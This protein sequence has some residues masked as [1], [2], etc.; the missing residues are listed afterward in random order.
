MVEKVVKA[1]IAQRTAWAWALIVGFFLVLVG[2]A[3]VVPIL[4]G[5]LLAV[6]AS[7]WH[8]RSAQ[9]VEAPVYKEFKARR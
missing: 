6:A 8:S 3:P 1:V 7:A 4:L 5:C 9:G 2:H